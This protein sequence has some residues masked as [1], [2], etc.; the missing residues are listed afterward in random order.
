MRVSKTRPII[1][2]GESVRA[3]LAGKKTQT[4][5]SVKRSH[6][7]GRHHGLVDGPLHA[8]VYTESMLAGH[9][10]YGILEDLLWVRET[11][12][13]DDYRFTRGPLPKASTLPDGTKFDSVLY[14]RAD[15]ECCQ[16]FEAC[17]CDEGPIGW[18]SP[19]FM[20]RWASRLTLEV[21]DVRVE[22]VQDISEEDA[23]AEGVPVGEVVP[24][25]INGEPGTGVIFNAR[26]LY[27]Q[28][29]ERI[30]AKRG[31]GW[32]SNPW[33]WVVEFRRVES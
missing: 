17:P 26:L 32:E 11:F 23:K 3:I 6:I 15:G 33:V 12:L 28:A 1:M 13:L 8:D 5:R 21:M 27:A 9:C 30:N 4:R 20:P 19:L 22:R 18:R 25:T 24:V 2:S 29:W 31:F 7:F 16:Q 14:F 10:P